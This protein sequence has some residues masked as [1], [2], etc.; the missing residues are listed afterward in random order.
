MVIVAVAQLKLHKVFLKGCYVG[1]DNSQQVITDAL[2]TE[3]VSTFLVHSS[4]ECCPLH[5]PFFILSSTPSPNISR[6]FVCRRSCMLK[7]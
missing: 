4:R 7:K 1:C 3:S 5:N 2:V 6:T